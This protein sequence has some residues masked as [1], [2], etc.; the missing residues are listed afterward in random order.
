M[1]NFSQSFKEFDSQSFM[2]KNGFVWWYGVVEDRFDPLYLGRVKVRIIGWHTD[3]KTPGQGIP[4]EDLPWADVVSPINSASMSGIGISPTGI[5]PGTHV[6]GFFRDG[7]EAQEPVVL[8]TIGGIPE[9]LANPDVGF[10][11]PRDIE[12]REMEPYPPLFIE[13][14]KGTGKSKIIDHFRVFTDNIDND[15]KMAEIHGVSSLADHGAELVVKRDD[16]ARKSEIQIR[17][18]E[19]PIGESLRS[20]FVIETPEKVTLSSFQSFSPHPDEN[21][22]SFSENGTLEFSLPSTNILASSK[23][24]NYNNKTDS[25]NPF[26]SVIFRSHRINAELEDYRVK[27]HSNIDTTNPTKKI[28][29]P[30]GTGT[31]GEPLYPYN[32]V[33]YTESGHLFEMDDTPKRERVRLMHRSTS[34]IEFLQDGDRVD[35]TVGEKFD[36]VDSNINTH[37]LGNS[38]TSVNGFFDLYVK[39]NEKTIA[40][41]ALSPTSSS[42]FNVKVDSGSATLMTTEGDVNIIAGGTGKVVLKGTDVVFTSGDG[43]PIDQKTFSLDNYN[44]S[45]EKMGRMSLHTRTT[46]I[47]SEG[48]MQLNSGKLGISTQDFSI[49]ASKTVDVSALMGSREV[50]NGLLTFGSPHTPSV[51]KEITTLAGKIELNS[52]FPTPGLT[53]IIMNVGPRGTLSKMSITPTGSSFISPTG[54]VSFS[55]GGKFR[56][57]T[58]DDF[59]IFATKNLTMRNV[60]GEVSIAK[61]GKLKFSSLKV[62]LGQVLAELMIALKGLS[63]PTGVGPS[64][65]PINTPAFEAVEQKLKQMLE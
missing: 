50:V 6:L 64:G 58:A 47:K 15:T 49:K 40:P 25:P 1:E 13:R 42:A 20:S 65:T 24:K 9:R 18:F 61:S 28:E 14:N 7:L 57:I 32:H 54:S 22:I 41:G 44:L 30:G 26:S 33:K 62:T 38:F 34:Y 19:K 52:V 59:N 53:G 55:T 3:N 39:G 51:G 60:L 2:G 5:V 10:F 11:D 29:Q 36:M 8:G 46:Q 21:R 56:V 43:K 31:S 12:I 16:I 45:G 37:A 63:V 27:L 4:T 17:G 48:E 23:Q 35:S